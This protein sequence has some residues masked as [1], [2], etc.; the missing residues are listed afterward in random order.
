MTEKITDEE[1]KRA[2]KWLISDIEACRHCL[3]DAAVERAK[4]VIEYC[5]SLRTQLKTMEDDGR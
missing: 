4:L 5:E 1:W 2:K 3:G